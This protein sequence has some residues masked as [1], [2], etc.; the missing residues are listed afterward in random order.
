MLY[1]LSMLLV[2]RSEKNGGKQKR[3]KNGRN[4]FIKKNNKYSTSSHLR[5]GLYTFF[6]SLQFKIITHIEIYNVCQIIIFFL[7]KH[8][9]SNTSKIQISDSKKTCRDLVLSDLICYTCYVCCLSKNQKKPEENK[10]D[11]KTGEMIFS[12]KITSIAHQVT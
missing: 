4:D 11:R 5:Q 9:F 7:N 10:K 12:K 3:P 6:W 2:K 8:K 1:L